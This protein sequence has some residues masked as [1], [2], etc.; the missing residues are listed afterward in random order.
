MY[1]RQKEKSH[2][3]NKRKPQTLIITTQYATVYSALKISLIPHSPNPMTT[4][5]SIILCSPLD[6][7]NFIRVTS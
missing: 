2:N 1:A 3:K 7:D 4:P 6:V 5:P